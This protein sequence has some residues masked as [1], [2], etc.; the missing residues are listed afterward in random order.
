MQNCAVGK[1]LATRS[2]LWFPTM[3]QF[4]NLNV[5][6]A[7]VLAGSGSSLV[8]MAQAAEPS[9]VSLQSP[10][11]RPVRLTPEVAALR[12]QGPAGLATFLK[13][14][15]RDLSTTAVLPPASVRST[16]DAL[17]QQR[18]CYASH[19]YWYTD[20][21]QAK[22]AAKASG[23]PIL[24][25]RLL[26]R[27]DEELSCAN[28]R[29]FRVALYANREVGQLLRDRFIL[30]WQSVRPVPKVTIDFGNG[31][32][33]ERTLTGNSIHYVLDSSGRP[34]EALPGLYGPQAFL[35]QLQQAEQAVQK[36]N[37]LPDDRWETALRQYHRDRL[38]ALQTQW[39]ADLTQLGVTPVPNLTA[40]PQDVDRRPTAEEAGRVA[41]AK[42]RV[43]TPLLSQFQQ[44]ANRNQATLA[45]VTD[46]ATWSKLAKRYAA[47]AK[48]DQNSLALMQAKKSVAGV[49]DSNPEVALYSVSRQFETAMAID[50]VRNEYLLHSQ[51]HQ[52]FVQPGTARDLDRLNQRV[53]AQ[54]FLTPNSD[55]WLGLVPGSGYAAIENEGIRQ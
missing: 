5:L 2:L 20:L 15:A 17:C 1:V 23:K 13:T 45:S 53:Y 28:S 3:M 4:R 34:V 44:I 36:L 29:F 40:L 38:A 31:R 55:P 7:L 30:H 52:W 6:I 26:G 41:I 48:L 19:L 11:S 33:L 18:D 27:L 54:L 8:V 37:S 10:V 49:E 12:Q 47:D 32:K 35:H 42:S 46:E 22:A 16:L 24:S 51:L 25:L 43:E 50:S 9:P 14:H 21:E 39:V